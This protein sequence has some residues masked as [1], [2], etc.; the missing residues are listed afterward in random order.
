MPHI[1][2]NPWNEREISNLFGK[3]HK[4]RLIHVIPRDDAEFNILID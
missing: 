1:M 4:V 2:R 3:K